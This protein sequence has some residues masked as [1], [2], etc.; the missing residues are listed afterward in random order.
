M[1][2]DLPMDAP[3]LDSSGKNGA[4]QRAT[5]ARIED[6]SDAVRDANLQATQLSAAP[7][8]GSL[9][10]TEHKGIVCSSGYL[11]GRVNL[12]G[13][14]SCD[15]VSLGVGLRLLP[16]CWQWTT[17]AETGGVGVFNSTDEHDALYAPDAL[18]AVLTLTE[19]QLEEEAAK[20]D[21]VLDRK[22][23]GGTGIHARR[24]PLHVID[25]FTKGFERIH[26][27]GLVGGEVVTD[28]L[29]VL[30]DHLGRPPIDHTRRLS[31]NQHARIV[32]RARHYIHDHLTE[33][34]SLDAIVAAAYTSRRTLYRAFADIL[35]DTPQTYVR[36]LRLHRI[37][38]DLASNAE[39]ACTITIIA[40]QWGI[41][42]LGRLA[43]WYRELFGERP[44]ETLA[45]AHV[46]SGGDPEL[47]DKKL[48]KNA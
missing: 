34:I 40:N 36:R 33:P 9:A 41:S 48:A 16:G 30:I 10:F 18:Y 20:Q 11:Q 6:L 2:V 4:F 19:E 46:S 28:L 47:P 31:R 22:V 3:T 13:P 25:P 15:K 39:K 12:Q 42:E 7:L 27:G 35:D 43:G 8:F 44:S 29:A 1:E 45:E 5:I 26:A 21:L 24:V 37:R 32:H 17:E 38:Q 14:L 23:L